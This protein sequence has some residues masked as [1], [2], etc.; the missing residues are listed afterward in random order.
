MA[1]RINPPSLEK[2]KTY[3]RFKQ[4]VLAWREITDLA[5]NKQGIAVALSLPEDDEHQIKDKV[6]DQIS[7]DDLKDNF[8]LDILIAF[9]DKHLAK[10]DLPDSLEKFDDFDDFRRNDGQAINEYNPMSDSKYRKIEKK[11]MTLPSEILAFKLLKKANIT[12]E[13]RLLVLTGM[14]Y[15][16]KSTLYEE[17]KASLKKFKGDESVQK[18]KSS[19]KLEPAYPAENEEALLAAGYV[20]SKSNSN[21]DSRR[22]AR[23]D[24]GGF[25]RSSS[26]RGSQKN[27]S[28]KSAKNKKMNPVGTDGR[29]LT[30]KCCGSFRHLVANCPDTWENQPKVNVIEDEHAVLF[31]GYN[32]D[33][34]ARL[35]VDARNCAV[36]DSACSSTVCG[37][38]WLD[39]YL[40]S[41]DKEDGGKVVQ[42]EGAKIFKFGGGTRLKSEGAYS[43]PAII[44]GKQ[45]TTRGPMVL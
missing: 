11:K 4:E 5:K 8:G 32:K 33:E 30:C 35:G 28:P 36:L 37:K 14:N 27:F 15:E 45:V 39:G 18:K 25:G 17:A 20:K 10:D 24:W 3:E 2:A 12:K 41:L 9:L 31:T 22:G 44:A 43:I 23:R 29:T 38:V 6:F 21:F 16:N 26:S 7:I 19:I 34:I 1:T 40:K 42:A 13:E